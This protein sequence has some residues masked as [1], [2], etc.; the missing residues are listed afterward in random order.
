MGH[1]IQFVEKHYP[2][3]YMGHHR[4]RVDYCNKDGAREDK[5]E[6]RCA[7]VKKKTKESGFV[8]KTLKNMD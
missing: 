5:I 3:F 1:A 6:W 2:H 8:C 7:K 4:V